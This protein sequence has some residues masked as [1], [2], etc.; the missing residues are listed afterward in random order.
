MN[1]AKAT[2]F[3]LILS[4]GWNASE[5]VAQ[6]DSLPAGVVAHYRSGELQHVRIEP[7]PAFYLEAGQV[8][9]PDFSPGKWSAH[10]VGVI[11]ILRPGR[12]R[13]EAVVR[14]TVRLRI[15]DREV[16]AGRAVNCPAALRGSGSS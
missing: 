13:F 9:A 5:L 15:G 6:D 4:V 12:Y 3:V 2:L 11:D 16:L 14:G 10:W 8:P 7:R 1:W